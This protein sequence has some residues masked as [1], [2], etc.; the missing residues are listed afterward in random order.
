MEQL[1]TGGN[2]EIYERYATRMHCMHVACEIMAF[3]L[4]DILYKEIVKKNPV[5]FTRRIEIHHGCKIY[6]ICHV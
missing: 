6:H 3:T 5:Y 2:T 4:T 1:V